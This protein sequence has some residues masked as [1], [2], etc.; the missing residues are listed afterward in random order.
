MLQRGTRHPR[1]RGREAQL[2]LVFADTWS[3]VKLAALISFVLAAAGLLLTVFGWN[4]VLM[5]GALRPIDE[6]LHDVT[7]DK[8]FSLQSSALAMP[9]VLR[10]VVPVAALAFFVGTVLGAVCAVLYNLAVHISGGLTVR[11]APAR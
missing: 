10:F 7:G 8:S 3:W 9:T 1:D 6:L 2:R 11:L 4:V 5:T